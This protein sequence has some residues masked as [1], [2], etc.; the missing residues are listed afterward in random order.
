M[1]TLQ[2][3]VEHPK[4]APLRIVDDHLVAGDSSHARDRAERFRGLRHDWSKRTNGNGAGL[5]GARA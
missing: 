2:L 5:L 1:L 4:P 3:P